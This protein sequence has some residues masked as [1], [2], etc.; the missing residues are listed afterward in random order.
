MKNFYLVLT[1]VIVSA[2]FF[3]SMQTGSVSTKLS[4]PI[5]D[6]VADTLLEDDGVA[7]KNG[8]SKKDDGES[9][10]KEKEHNEALKNNFY[11]AVEDKI[12]NMAHSFLFMCLGFSFY[13]YMSLRGGMN[14]K[15]AL[16]VF[17]ICCLYG[18]LDEIK[19]HFVPER[20]FA[21]I[22]VVMDCIGAAVGVCAATLRWRMFGFYK[23]KSR[24]KQ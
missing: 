19:Q 3:F 5:S 12:R 6:R 21:A 1:L 9:T 22:D 11:S 16:I 23:R 24:Q 20:D 10:E 15:K 8:I 13:M 14:R 18:L 17:G 2:I 4:R 7:E